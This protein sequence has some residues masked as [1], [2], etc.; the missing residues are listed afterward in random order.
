MDN[1]FVS[2]DDSAQVS[3]PAPILVGEQQSVTV[4]ENFVRYSNTTIQ[5][6]SVETLPSGSQA[7]VENV[8]T[9]INAIF[10]FGIPEGEQG[11]AGEDGRNGEAATIT[12]GSTTT[13]EPETEAS[14][15]NS[16][17]S[18]AAVLNFVIPKG[19]K[20]DQGEQGEAATVDVGTIVSIAP[21]ATPEV[22]NSGTVHDAILNFAIPQGYDGF[23]PVAT[24]TQNTGSATISITD[25]NGTTTATVYDGQDGAPGQTGPAGQDGQAATIT[26]GSTTTGNAGTN[27]SV[28]NSGTSSAAVLD[29]V[30]PRG[31]D[32]QNG[33]NGSDGTDGFSPIA[34]VTQNTGSATISIT[35]ANGTTTATVYDGTS[36]S[37]VQTTGQ[38]TTDAMSQ[39]ATTD[40]LD[41]KQDKLGSHWKIVSI[42]SGTNK[43]T[44]PSGYR[45]YRLSMSCT[46][47][48][49]S[50]SSRP[51]IQCNSLTANSYTT[52]ISQIG[53]NSPTSFA[54]NYSAGDHLVCPL[55]GSGS[56]GNLNP[57]VNIELRRY[58]TSSAGLSG[59]YTATGGG[60]DWTIQGKIE[61]TASASDFD[62]YIGRVNSTLSN[63]VGYVEAL[64]E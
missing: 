24:V 46:T 43:W 64:E 4:E 29:F 42:V 26:I 59:F 5:V 30:I 44:I 60:A 13:G 56:S 15:T 61:I 41:L 1:V 11:I 9:E 49:P 34:T 38:S 20:G 47:S 18:S 8:G 16:G 40:A 35:D 12:V 39:K 57:I 37:L 52:G 51:F 58:T 63:F 21:D 32:G 53:S 14:V 23:S 6:G 10:N 28:T 19:E 45:F 25:E 27:A 33:T 54:S 2:I 17:S 55:Y 50:S 36:P 7:Y 31:A 3:Q 48:A 22:N 62:L